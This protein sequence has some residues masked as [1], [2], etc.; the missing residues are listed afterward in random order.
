MN[1]QFDDP[2]FQD[3]SS[4]KNAFRQPSGEVNSNPNRDKFWA[5]VVDAAIDLLCKKEHQKVWHSQGLDAEVTSPN[6]RRIAQIVDEMMTPA[7]TEFLDKYEKFRLSTNSPDLPFV[8]LID[9]A[10]Y[11][12]CQYYFR[13]FMWVLD[14]VFV[15]ILNRI[16]KR[17]DNPAG[18]ADDIFFLFFGTHSQIPL[19]APDEHQ[20]SEKI[21][22]RS[23]ALPLVFLNFAWDAS[24][25]F[26]PSRSLDASNDV[27]HLSQYGRPLWG[28]YIS[29]LDQM[30]R[31]LLADGSAQC[32]DVN[33]IALDSLPRN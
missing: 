30:T 21:F 10:G 25:S 19:S 14:Q 11:L 27:R 16:R 23:Q 7:I 5:T 24:Y 17:T 26:P 28:S 4:W 12:R 13:A 1:K 33:Q 8:F 15:Q 20:P 22:E 3:L 2:G 32:K 6:N 31:R 29:G 18:Q 9:E